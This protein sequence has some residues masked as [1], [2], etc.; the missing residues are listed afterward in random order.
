MRV[1]LIFLSFFHLFPIL[2]AQTSFPDNTLIVNGYDQKVSGD[3][4]SY[5]SSVPLARECML[6][7]ATDGN[8]S[9]EWK[10]DPVIVKPDATSATIVWLAGIGS[11]PGTASFDLAVNGVK[12]FTFVADGS[13]QWSYTADD[14]S[15]LSFQKDMTDQHGDRFGFMYLT[16][17]AAKLK[18]G[19][20]KSVV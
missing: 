13:D 7:R 2:S 4:F 9:M 1:F 11:S 12:K 19:D 8:S 15:I 6:I 5:H 10:T 14:G 18:Y 20:R 3:D 17:P 16:I